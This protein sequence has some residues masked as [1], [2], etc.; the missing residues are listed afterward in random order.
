MR[1]RS[2]ASKQRIIDSGARIELLLSGRSTS[3]DP[4]FTVGRFLP[5]LLAM[6]FIVLIIGAFFVIEGLYEKIWSNTTGEPFT[7][8]MRRIP[9]Y[10]LIGVA[11]ACIVF[12]VLPHNASMR[13]III[14]A[15]LIIG[16]VGGHVFWGEAPILT[17]G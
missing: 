12:A 3:N 5:T 8:I 10:Y 7:D 2:L 11:C 4:F 16:F 14:V 9:G 17:A 13:L 6:A 15:A 1:L